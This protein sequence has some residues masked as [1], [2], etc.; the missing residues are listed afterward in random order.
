MFVFAHKSGD[1]EMVQH[2]PVSLFFEKKDPY[3]RVELDLT[4][5]EQYPSDYRHTVSRR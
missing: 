1:T 2:I 4:L 5:Q 3:T